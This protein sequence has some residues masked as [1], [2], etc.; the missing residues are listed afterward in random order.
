MEDGSS[1]VQV[2][3]QTEQIT[4]FDVCRI[5]GED[6]I[7]MMQSNMDFENPSDNLCWMKVGTVHDLS[8]DG[9]TFELK[10]AMPGTT[11]PVT[12][13]I[14]NAG[15]ESVSRIGYKVTMQSADQTEKDTGRRG[16]RCNDY[17]R[18]NSTCCSQCSDT[19]K[20]FFQKI[21]ITEYGR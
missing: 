2:T 3:A 6:Y 21:E 19:G 9:T 15:S 13:K 17:S 5:G 16:K 10:D 1:P 20:Y 7:T 12:L 14:R 11:L 8:L 18:R 4:S